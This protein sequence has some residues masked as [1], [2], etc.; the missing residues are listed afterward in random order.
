MFYPLYV[1]P[2]IFARDP[3][4]PYTIFFYPTVV[5]SPLS[6]LLKSSRS[7]TRSPNLLASTP[8]CLVRHFLYHV[9]PNFLIP[10]TH[11]SHID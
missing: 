1:Y 6:A 4:E 9:E 11:D 5:T 7:T 2:E 3:H 10:H 8:R